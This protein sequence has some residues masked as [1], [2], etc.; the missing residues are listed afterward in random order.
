MISRHGI[1][2]IFSTFAQFAGDRF[3]KWV[4]DGT[5]RRSMVQAQQ[6][7][8]IQAEPQIALERFWTLYWYKF[9]QA[10]PESLATGHLSAYLQEVCYWAADKSTQAGSGQFSIADCFQIAIAAL[11]VILRDY[12][13]AQG[14]SLKTY[15][16]LVFSNTIRDRLRQQREADRRTDWGLLRKLSQKQL[17]EALETAGFSTEKVFS[18]RL[19]W[20]SFK[21]VCVPGDM[22][23][24][25]HLSCPTPAQWAAIAQFY[26]AQRQQLPAATPELAEHWLLA[27]AKHVRAYLYPSLTS[28]NLPKAEPSGGEIQDDLPDREDTSPLTV[29]LSQEEMQ[30][31][32]DQRS[33]VHHV[34]AT[35]LQKLDPEMQTL[36]ELYCRQGL[37]Q[38]EIAAQ[39]G[40][41]QYTISRRLT[42]AREKLLLA[43]AQW[44]QETLH[45]SLTST[46]VKAM[47]VV[48][49]E[50]LQ[51]KFSASSKDVP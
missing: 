1:T 47:S 30:A 3:A 42:S 14:A 40:I 50:W 27:C 12:N 31:R 13:P 38:Q 7:V 29:L 24:T 28:L 45:I 8:V 5:L 35:A 33:Q 6:Q 10:Q 15:A 16:S 32:Q 46:A 41:K 2:A 43:I 22:P 48:L 23:A 34:L 11:P 20:I 51:E 26:N 49:E 44:S 4:T 36:L 19:A 39:L 9:W 37:T 25:R 17:V 21:S 18:Y